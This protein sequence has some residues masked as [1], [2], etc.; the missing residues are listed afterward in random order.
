VLL[1][2]D[3]A[4]EIDA[5]RAI[6]RDY[7]ASLDIDLEF[8]DFDSELADLPGEYAEPRGT[9]LLALV[10]PANIKEEAG[11]QAPMLRRADS[12]LAHVAGCCALR[13]LDNATT[14]TRRK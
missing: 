3:E 11:R 8:Q 4:H 9:L 13:P 7:A 12:S 14:R 5:A 10:D 2:P 1:T 6:F